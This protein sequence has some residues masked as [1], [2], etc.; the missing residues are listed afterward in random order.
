[1]TAGRSRRKSKARDWLRAPA[2]KYELGDSQA[3]A[4]SGAE[5]LVSG[6]TEG[7]D[8]RDGGTQG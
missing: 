5:L 8:C 2:Q 6:G 3:K 4:S 1:M 7:Q